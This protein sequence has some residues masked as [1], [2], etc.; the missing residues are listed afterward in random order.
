MRILLTGT[1]PF[2]EGGGGASTALHMQAK[3]LSEDGHSVKVVVS[4][5][6]LHSPPDYLDGFQLKVFTVLGKGCCELMRRF[7]WITGQFGVLLY[8]FRSI[9]TRQ[10]DSII[11]YGG[12]PIFALAAVLGKLLNNHTCFFQGDIVDNHQYFT[13]TSEKILLRNV[14]LVLI[15]GSSLLEKRLVEIAPANTFFRLWPITYTDFFGSGNA[16]RAK[17]KH[18]L[19]NKRIIVYTGAISRLEGIDFLIESMKHVVSKYPSAR[20][21]IAG[22]ILERD[23]VNGEP[24]DYQSLIN[25]LDLTSNVMLVGLLR[26]SEVADL[27]ASADV[28]VNPKIDHLINRMAVPIKIGEYLASGRPIVTTPVCDLD[29]WLTD[30]EHVLFCK[31]GDSESLAEGICAILSDINLSARLSHNG[32]IVARQHCDYRVWSKRVAEM[33]KLSEH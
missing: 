8:L 20:L 16:N 17:K 1:F 3:G 33:I 22:R 29:K 15:G 28:L 2:P 9:V 7:Y 31:P 25:K 5:S 24:I 26:I 19:D 18:V 10:F 30:R 13:V 4:Q 32:A 27:L 11:F 23:P 14:S 12:A 21:V 6:S